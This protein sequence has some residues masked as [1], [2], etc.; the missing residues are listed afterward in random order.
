MNCKSFLEMGFNFHG[1]RCPAMPL[2]LRAGLK[3]METLAVQRS[4]DKELYVISLDTNECSGY[5]RGKILHL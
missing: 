3:A 2:G 1:H 5:F 4:E